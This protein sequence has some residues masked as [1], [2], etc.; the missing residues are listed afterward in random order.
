M[1]RRVRNACLLF[2]LEAVS[3]VAEV[4]DPA[5]DAI[6]VENP[7]IR[8]A[9][10]NEETSEVTGSLDGRG[11]IAGGVQVTLT[12]DTYLKGSG[13]AATPPEIGP[14]LEATGWEEVVQAAALPV[15]SQAA[16]AGSA[17][18]A[19]GGAAFVAVAQQYRGMPLLLTVNPVG[20]AVSFITDY[21]A[22]K[23]FA[24]SESFTP[25]LDNTTNLQIPAHVLYRPIS[26]DIPSGT[27]RFYVDGVLH[28]VFG[29]RGDVTLA[30]PAAKAGRLSWSFTGMYGGKTDAAVPAPVYDATRPPIFR[31]GLLTIARG[32][33]AAETLS[34]R[35]G[36]TL[37]YPPNPNA[38]E[39][40]DPSEI[41][42]RAMSGTIDPLET[43]VATRDLM[44]VLRSGTPQI[45]H[46]RWGSVAGNRVALTM[47]RAVV[48]GDDPGDRQGLATE[49]MAFACTGE[50]AG[51]FLCFF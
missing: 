39:G 34:L 32:K 35:N 5:L 19:T 8:Y 3:G 49:T 25:A 11:P 21:S 51:A 6:L 17:T 33:A 40:F 13:A 29:A 2:K 38:A 10:Q 14:L 18:S 1:A 26:D 27:F 45:V 37:V 9:P 4:P 15:A 42:A 7:R 48:T 24:L 23:V 50:D 20:G 12:F 16:T 36:N 41:T 46:A 30:A 22:G 31:D 47:P 43:L 44:S 28:T